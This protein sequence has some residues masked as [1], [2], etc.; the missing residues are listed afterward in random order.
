MEFGGREILIGIGLLLVVAILLDGFRRARLRADGKLRVRRRRQP[1]FS[2][3]EFDEHNAE[4][5][6]V[7]VVK[8]RD[9][10]SAELISQTLKRNAEKNHNKLTKPFRDEPEQVALGL[11][12]A[13]EIESESPLAEP[14]EYSEPP[15]PSAEPVASDDAVDQADLAQEVIAVH[16]MAPQGEMFPGPDLL[17]ALLANGLRFGENSI[18]HRHEQEDGSG[19]VLFSVT[20]A[21]KPGIF[22][23]DAMAEFSTPGLTFFMVMGDTDDPMAAFEAMLVTLD[24]LR[25]ALGGDMKDEN[26]STLTRQTAEHNRQRIMEYRRRQLTS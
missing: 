2:D 6:N 18:F 25:S 14:S 19:A 8:V 17:E 23:L 3:D 20:N 12:D 24:A 15:E 7:R 22:E 13:D 5:G 1:I 10:Q 11:E 9:E 16:L 4:L 21:V 26:R